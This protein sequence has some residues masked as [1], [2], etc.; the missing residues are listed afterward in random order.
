MKRAIAGLAAVGLLLGSTAV[1][2]ETAL[3][4]VTPQ[5][6]KGGTFRLTSKASRNNTVEFVIRRDVSKIEGPGRSAYL[7]NP[8]VDG[9]G[10][11]TPVKLEEDGKVLIFPFS[12]P[13]DRVAD[14]VFTLWGGGKVGEGVT[15]RFRLAEFWKPRKD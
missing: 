14:S 13:A 10:L 9:R 3:M 2:A 11:G 1:W 4:Y 15:Y 7:S 5:N 12:V 8:K 6:I